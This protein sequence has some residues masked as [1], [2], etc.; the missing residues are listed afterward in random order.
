M[1]LESENGITQHNNFTFI[2]PIWH[3]SHNFLRGCLQHLLDHF[4][5]QRVVISE[6]YPDNFK[7]ELMALLEQY[8]GGLRIE[9]LH[10][11]LAMSFPD[12]LLECVEQVQTE[13][14]VLIADDDYAIPHGLHKSVQF[15]LDNKDYSACVGDILYITEPTFLKK[16]FVDKQPACVPEGA[17]IIRSD[18][19]YPLTSDSVLARVQSILVSYFHLVYSVCRTVAFAHALRMTGR[20]ANTNFFSQYLI[21]VAIVATGKVMVVN[22]LYYLRRRRNQSVAQA[23]LFTDEAMP[24]LLLNPNFSGLFGKFFDGIVALVNPESDRELL[25]LKLYIIN[26]V[27]K[28]MAVH[29]SFRENQ[30]LFR[31]FVDG[32]EVLAWNDKGYELV[33]PVFGHIMNESTK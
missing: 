25:S 31:P 5:G 14:T 9:V 23:E 30:V 4:P 19:A 27:R 33:G 11:P 7:G 22:S 18:M 13:L 28:K 15:L 10:H 1:S 32:R 3:P 20:Y 6:V 17:S 21:T 16:T 29:I 24:L 12:R 8:R 26:F 2:L